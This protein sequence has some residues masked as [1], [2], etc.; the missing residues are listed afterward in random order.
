MTAGPALSG[1]VHGE[2]DEAGGRAI[3]ITRKEH[4]ESNKRQGY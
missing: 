3:E 2:C 4:R 1:I